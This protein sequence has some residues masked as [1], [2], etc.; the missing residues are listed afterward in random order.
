MAQIIQIVKLQEGL[1]AKQKSSYQRVFL[2]THDQ[3]LGGSTNVTEPAK[4]GHDYI[5]SHFRSYLSIGS[6][7]LHSVTC[8]MMPRKC[9]LRTEN[10]MAMA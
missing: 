4:T 1:S 7:Y 2:N 6:D 8:I 3:R 9:L 10:C 5:L